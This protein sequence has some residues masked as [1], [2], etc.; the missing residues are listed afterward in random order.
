MKITITW[1]IYL[2]IFFNCTNAYITKQSSSTSVNK[3]Y[4]KFSSSPFTSSPEH[5]E[6]QHSTFYKE[7]K[8][9]GIKVKIGHAFKRY[10]NGIAI[11]TDERHVKRIAEIEHVDSVEPVVDF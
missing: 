10:A 11:E 6:A 4:V 5:I 8:E 9:R 3:Y 1:F 2:L 7:L